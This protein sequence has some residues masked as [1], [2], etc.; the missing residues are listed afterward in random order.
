MIQRIQTLYLIGALIAITVLSSFPVVKFEM[1]NQLGF[2]EKGISVKKVEVY[3]VEDVQY[4]YKNIMPSSKIWHIINLILLTL[5]AFCLVTAIFLYQKR[6]WQ[7]ILCWVSLVFLFIL[8]GLIYVDLNSFVSE[9]WTQSLGIGA[10]SLSASLLLILLA[11]K[12]IKKDENL[13]RSVDR[14]R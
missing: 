7:L 8:S 14:I 2:S 11:R 9:I 3:A 6:R 10:F 13:V 5:T 4:A 12:G 1:K